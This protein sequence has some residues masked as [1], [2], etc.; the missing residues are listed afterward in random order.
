[1]SGIFPKRMTFWPDPA[2]MDNNGTERFLCGEPE[3]AGYKT[4]AR[5]GESYCAA[6]ID[7]SEKKGSV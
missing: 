4:R 5:S 6:S 3:D 2:L 7:N 1:M